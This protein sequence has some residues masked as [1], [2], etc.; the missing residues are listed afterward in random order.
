MC[1]AKPPAMQANLDFWQ[2]AH[3]LLAQSETCIISPENKDFD[4][5][6]ESAAYKNKSSTKSDSSVVTRAIIHFILQIVL[7]NQPPPPSVV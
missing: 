7:T 2:N 6:T 1:L 3:N 5:R 4:L